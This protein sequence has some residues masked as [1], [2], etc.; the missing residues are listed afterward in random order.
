M[1]GNSDSS[2]RQQDEE[3]GLEEVTKTANSSHEP[4]GAKAGVSVHHT[5]CDVCLMRREERS[6]ER[7]AHVS[8]STAHNITLLLLQHQMLALTLPHTESY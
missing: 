1:L 7:D 2:F 3:D 4:M 6:S 5:F 8:H